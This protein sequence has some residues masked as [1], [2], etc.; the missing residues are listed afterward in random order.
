MESEHK[1]RITAAS[2]EAAISTELSSRRTEMSRSTRSF[3]R[4]TTQKS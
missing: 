2:N 3:K 4:R 1:A